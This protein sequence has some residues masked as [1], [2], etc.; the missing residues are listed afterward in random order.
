M[1]PLAF[2][3]LR[4]EEVFLIL[5]IVQRTPIFNVL[6]NNFPSFF[7]ETVNSGCCTPNSE[8]IEITK[9]LVEAGKIVGI[10]IL[11]HIII[12]DGVFFS[13]TRIGAFKKCPFET[14]IF[15]KSS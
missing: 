13:F 9:R 3:Y 4:R 5:Y 11:D 6:S 12:G 15:S 2:L 7:K 8:D 14:R 10:E 1:N